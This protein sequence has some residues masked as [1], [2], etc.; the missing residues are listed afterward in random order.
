MNTQSRNQLITAAIT[1]SQ[2]ATNCSDSSSSSED[3]SEIQH[4]LITCRREKV[5]RNSM[6]NYFETTVLQKY[7]QEEFIRHFR[8]QAI[9]FSKLSTEYEQTEAYQKMIKQNPSRVLRPDKTLAIFLWFA[10]HEACSYRDLSDRFNVS[11][12]TVHSAILRAV[13][14]LTNLAPKVIQWPSAAEMRE[15]ADLREARSNIPGII[16]M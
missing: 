1:V 10:G 13:A 7:S 5:P 14:F 3:E 2:F 12:S 15:E 16:G 6:E 4:F 9:L 11:L 8:I